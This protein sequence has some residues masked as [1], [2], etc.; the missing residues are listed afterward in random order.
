MIRAALALAVLVVP[1]AMASETIVRDR[2]ALQAAVASAKPGDRIL[3]AP[4][5][6]EGGL[7]FRGVTGEPGNRIVIAALDSTNPPVFDGG[8]QAMH[9]AGASHL[10]LRDLV[11]A[12]MTGNGWN[13]DDGGNFGSA[14][15]IVLSG[16]RVRDVGPEGNRDGIKLSGL[17]GFVVEN[18]VVERWG[19]G[20]SGID[21]VGCHNGL[22]AGCRFE[23]TPTQTSEGVQMKGGTA[24]V[25]VR[26]N[27]F[28]NAGR[29]VN[30]G[31]S[32]GLEFFRPALNL[33]GS[34]ENSEA[35]AIVVEG[36]TFIGSGAAVAFVGVDRA[37]VRYNTI[38]RP[39]RWA[40]RILQENRS[41]TFVPSRNGVFERNLI[42]FR[43]DAWASS[44]VNIG[45]NTA[46][47]TFRFA[48]NWWYCLD[49]PARSHPDLPTEEAHG[50]YGVDPALA[51]PEAGDFAPKAGSPA[52]GVGAH[53]LPSKA[54]P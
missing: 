3:I 53:A 46:P 40:L 21:M 5:T 10:E 28:V 50:T 7:Y 47:E 13:L 27:R 29:G 12:N 23:T 4:G 14:R 6:Y 41:E 31:G 18:C 39:G 24:D 42:A 25:V 35:R 43:S 51:D 34:M 36:N 15:D 45:P 52:A 32:T 22:I 33:D 20:G 26:G 9:I 1:C 19:T 17:N 37:V 48:S 16:I 30:I 11:S 38:Y 8:G 2:N 44:G 54:T 49:A